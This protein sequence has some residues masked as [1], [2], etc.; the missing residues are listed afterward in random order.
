ML[1]VC[2]C[3]TANPLS[4]ASDRD[5]E[6]T[7]HS[8]FSERARP[9]HPETKITR[10]NWLLPD[11]IRWG[12]RNAREIVPTSAIPNALAASP[13]SSG[14]P[15]RDSELAIQT[16]DGQTFGMA[17]YLAEN[18]VDGLLVMHGGKIVYE[19]YF[20][21]MRP[22]DVHSWASMSKSMVGLIAVQLAQQGRIDLD[23]PLAAYVPE[24]RDSPFGQ[25]SVQQ[26]MDMQL[27]L[28]Y[29]QALPPD[30]GMFAAAGLLPA[31]S[32]MPDSIHGFLK[33]PQA[34][35]QPAGG[36][37]YYQNGSTEAVAW[38]LQRVTGRSLSDLVAD[39]IW[40]PMGA[41]DQAYYPLDAAG[42]EFASG[43]LHSTL[44]DAARFGELIRTQGQVQGRQV[45]ARQAIE[46]ILATPSAANQARVRQSGRAMPSGTG[47]ADFWWHPIQASGAVIAS[48]RFGQRILVDPANALTIVQF[49]TYPDTRARPATAGQAITRQDNVLRTDDG[50]VAL[51][52][53]VS[54]QLQAAR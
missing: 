8:L 1:L 27:A 36:I 43:G 53:A 40:Q 41:Q 16:P 48:G 19:R 28:K 38:A 29:P 5:I 7:D 44:R 46:R 25:A 31:R 9:L 2:G 11:N 6:K 13:L 18:H 51:A 10:E 32:G 3:Q 21:G 34:M 23:A 26:N 4:S 20:N 22:R 45:V 54:R 30:I 37:F 15:I 52:R 35:E 33:A 50:L 12:L 14:S 39:M 47:Y 17:H 24:L 42:S 49:G